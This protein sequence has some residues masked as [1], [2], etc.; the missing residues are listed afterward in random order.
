MNIKQINQFSFIWDMSGTEY[1]FTITADSKAEAI[2]LLVQNLLHIIKD[3][4]K[5][6]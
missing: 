6:R 3:L 2:E 5:A 1:K 4:D